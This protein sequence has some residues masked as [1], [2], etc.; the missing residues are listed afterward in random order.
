MRYLT[1]D[2]TFGSN[3]D[4]RLTTKLYYQHSCVGSTILPFEN[5]ISV[6]GRHSPLTEALSLT[7]LIQTAIVS[8]RQ[9]DGHTLTDRQTDTIRLAIASVATHWPQKISNNYRKRCNEENDVWKAVAKCRIL[10]VIGWSAERWWCWRTINAGSCV[11][12][13]GLNVGVFCY[14]I[15]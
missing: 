2:T 1:C 15:G 8:E 11:C 9:T 6:S 10:S 5:I 3:H 13:V 7:V 4:K 14:Q 12:F